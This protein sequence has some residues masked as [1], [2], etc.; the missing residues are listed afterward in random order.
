MSIR[1]RCGKPVIM[2]LLSPSE[3]IQLLQCFDF[4][5]FPLHFTIVGGRM[6]F[7]LF[8]IVLSLCVIG[9]RG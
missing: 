3:K 7:F 6:F 5:N 9:Y 2:I 8:F 1:V 4:L